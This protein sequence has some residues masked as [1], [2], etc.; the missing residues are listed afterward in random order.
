[1]TMNRHSLNT[2]DSEEIEFSAAYGS[3]ILMTGTC[4]PAIR[5]RHPETLEG[6]SGSLATR[7]NIAPGTDRHLGGPHFFQPDDKAHNPVRLAM[8]RSIP[9]AAANDTGKRHQGKR[10]QLRGDLNRRRKAA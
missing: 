5:S 3:A 4:R 7:P 2:T 8:R 1:M 10:P 6:G 9:L